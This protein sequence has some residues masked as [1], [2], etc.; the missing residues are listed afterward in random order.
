LQTATSQRARFSLTNPITLIL[1]TPVYLL[2]V[3]GTE[4]LEIIQRNIKTKKVKHDVL[5]STSVT[6]GKDKSVTVSPVRVLG[7][8]LEELGEQGMGHW[9]TAHGSTL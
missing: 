5:K 2:A 1:I 7:V 6:V 8:N 3:N 9:S 4:L